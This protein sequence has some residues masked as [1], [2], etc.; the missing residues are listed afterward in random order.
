MVESGSSRERLLFTAE[1]LTN[2]GNKRLYKGM[3]ITGGR[4]SRKWKIKGTNIARAV[5]N[6]QE[7]LCVV[8]PILLSIPAAM[9]RIVASARDF[10]RSK[11]EVPGIDQ[12]IM[13]R[14]GRQG[15]HPMRFSG[16]FMWVICGQRMRFRP[17]AA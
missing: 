4:N 5:Q 12:S 8:L 9:R 11:I 10:L 13:S 1:F 16:P 14:A 17:F 6:R 15:W 2:S 7:R 3:V